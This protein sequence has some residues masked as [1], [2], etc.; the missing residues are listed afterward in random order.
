MYCKAVLHTRGK[1]ITEG[2]LALGGG[3]G[4]KAGTC[5]ECLYLSIPP[6][7]GTLYTGL[8]V[9]MGGKMVMPIFHF[10]ARQAFSPFRCA[11]LPLALEL[12]HYD[13]S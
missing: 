11:F 8:F 9:T 13:A 10:V 7:C 5:S 12:F 6:A 2:N 4:E 3:G 1:P